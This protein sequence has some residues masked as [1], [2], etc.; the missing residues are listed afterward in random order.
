MHRLSYACFSDL[1]VL[2]VY[3]PS[4][5]DAESATSSSSGSGCPSPMPAVR[6]AARGTTEA[7]SKG[8]LVHNSKRSANTNRVS[9]V[10]SASSSP[11]PP[12]KRPQHK[13]P[14]RRP[15]TADVNHRQ[16]PQMPY[17]ART[18]R[19]QTGFGIKSHLH[20][21]YDD[22]DGREPFQVGNRSFVGWFFFILSSSI[23]VDGL[24]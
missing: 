20:E 1:P 9:F 4:D 12:S 6:A 22:P 13:A 16:P 17:H 14:Q 2:T 19:R 7:A 3:M 8:I 11:S 15:S 5:Y 18:G 10:S 21:F 24:P 23:P